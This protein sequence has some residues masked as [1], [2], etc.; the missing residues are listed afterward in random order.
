MSEVGAAVTALSRHCASTA[1][2]Y[3]MHQIQVACVVRHGHSDFFREYFRDLVEHQ[4]LLAS[5][6]T[7]A[8]I[9]GD[10]RTSS[11]AVD[12]FGDRFKLQKNAPVIS[13]GA[14]LDAVLV[15]TRREPD[16]A[17]ND[18]VLVLCAPPGLTLEP[19]G[20]WD[21]FGFWWL[22]AASASISRQRAT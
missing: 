3:A 7:E 20:E 6:T 16:S 19:K 11:Y 22:R 1:M 8:G 5:A 18:Q 10:T 2:I 21:T 15:T 14:D 4:P 9:G 13:Y 12:R 17:P